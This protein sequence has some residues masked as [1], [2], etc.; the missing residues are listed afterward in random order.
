MSQFEDFTD[1]QETLNTLKNSLIN[2][3]S[4]VHD[5]LKE[6]QDLL[7]NSQEYIKEMSESAVK[8]TTQEMY[9]QAEHL[10]KKSNSEKN[11]KYF[12]EEAQKI[13]ELTNKFAESINKN[14]KEK[15]NNE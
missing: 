12:S 10:Y 8:M 15:M 13:N 3:R 1:D 5:M 7:Y 11:G 4:Y 9:E 2:M 14:I 6:R